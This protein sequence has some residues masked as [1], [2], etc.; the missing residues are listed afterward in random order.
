[1]YDADGLAP[2]R[3]FLT[4][5]NATGSA[6]A[7][8]AYACAPVCSPTSSLTPAPSLGAPPP[9]SPSTDYASSLDGWGAAGG[10]SPDP[11]ST[12]PAP[13]DSCAMCLASFG[14]AAGAG[15]SG[16]AGAAAAAGFSSSDVPQPGQPYRWMLPEQVCKIRC[17]YTTY[18]T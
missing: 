5:R 3:Y 13:L 8:T 11:A 10:S 12:A 6:G 9:S 17:V 4:K 16:D 18:T 1:M 15:S 14:Q 7:A 2:A